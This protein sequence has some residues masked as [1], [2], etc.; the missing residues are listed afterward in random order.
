MEKRGLF[1]LIGAAA[2]LTVACD[3]GVGD[4]IDNR[5]DCRQICEKYESC[6]GG[7]DFDTDGCTSECAENAKNDDFETQVDECESCLD[8]EDSCVE[9][10]FECTDDCANVVAQSS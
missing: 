4:K 7:E 1:M 5:T 6:L 9:D 10:G 3:D 8:D 2:L